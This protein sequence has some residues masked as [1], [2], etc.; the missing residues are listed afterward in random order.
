MS[1]SNAEEWFAVF[2]GACVCPRQLCDLARL[3]DGKFLLL[4]YWVSVPDHNCGD[5]ARPEVKV[6]IMY[7]NI[8][9]VPPQ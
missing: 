2:D 9:G 5:V 7:L 6:R 4:R 1:G 3:V 8:A